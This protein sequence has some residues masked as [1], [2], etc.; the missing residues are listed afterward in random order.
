MTKHLQKE[1]TQMYKKYLHIE[2]KE[3]SFRILKSSD[4]TNVHIW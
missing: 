2:G 1:F 4:K 3:T